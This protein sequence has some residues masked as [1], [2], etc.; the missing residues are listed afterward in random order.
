M[1]AFDGDRLD[2]ALTH[3]DVVLVLSAHNMDTA[4]HALRKLLRPTRD[5]FALRWWV[6]G[7][8]GADRGPTPRSARRNLFGF[9]DGTGNPDT[10]DDALMRRARLG[11]PRGGTYHGGTADPHAPRVLGPRRPRRAGL[12][13]GRRRDSSPARR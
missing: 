7:F 5:A 3:G 4:S 11:R 8:Q 12:M 9:R 2:P 6:D 13:I 10:F 1:T